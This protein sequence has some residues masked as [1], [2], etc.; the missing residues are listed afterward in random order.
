MSAVREDRHRVIRNLV[1]D[2]D[3]RTQSA[4]AEALREHGFKVTQATVSRDITDLGLQKNSK[5]CYALSEDRRL[6]SLV[7]TVVR[8]TRRAFNQVVVLSDPGTASS[9]AAAIDAADSPGVLGCIAG[10]DTVLVIAADEAEA[11]QFQRKID[12][13]L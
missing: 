11:I 7:K 3:I 4:L 8:E 12:E 1:R 5:G 10:D 2:N 13:M 9:V 6:Q